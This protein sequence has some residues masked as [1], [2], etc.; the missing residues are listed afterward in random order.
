MRRII[1]MF[2]LMTLSVIST[3]AQTEF[4]ATW[5]STASNYRGTVSRI[6]YVCPPNGS[7]ATVWGSDLYTDD[8]SVCN[9]AVH[10]GLITFGSGGRVTIEIRAG[11][12]SYQGTT[13]NG[14]TT[15]SYGS[16]GGSYVFV[17]T[18]SLGQPTTASG[19]IER[20]LKS[21]DTRDYVNAIADFNEAIRLEPGN[22]YGYLNRGMAHT[23]NGNTEQAMADTNRAVELLPSNAT[24]FANRSILYSIAKN[25]IA[26]KADAEKAINLDPA[27]GRGYIARGF[28][29]MADNADAALS[30]IDRGIQL[31]PSFANAYYFRGLIHFDKHQFDSARSD[32]QKAIDLRSDIDDLPK[33]RDLA[34]EEWKKVSAPPAPLPMIDITTPPAQD[35]AKQPV[36]CKSLE[37]RVPNKT[38]A[39]GEPAFFA[40]TVDG[41]YF[42]RLERLG[43]AWSTTAGKLNSTSDESTAVLDTST[44]E[45]PT[46]V[47]VTVELGDQS[48]P[49]CR[50][51]SFASASVRI[52]AP[53]APE[54]QMIASY[55]IPLDETANALILNE[56]K[57]HAQL[58]KAA[59]IGDELQVR[60]YS[61]PGA[62][63]SQNL[64]LLNALRQYL[65]SNGADVA[66]VKFV[67]KGR[68]DD[69]GIELW[70]APKSAAKP[71]AKRR[72]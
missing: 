47:T 31:E 28:S 18:A 68:R 54:G 17:G 14:I 51:R 37:V 21:V 67:D 12:S 53:V 6:T 33:W 9:A 20:G 69:A 60:A 2:T 32:F 40:A 43:Y 16:W 29:V 23:R 58:V 62:P 55:Y 19:F 66:A 70:M 45:A 44:I 59:V 35:T 52:A 22:G 30:D 42:A 34:F 7:L 3:F 26:A 72:R 39:P 27:Y 61:G 13:R 8:S 5:S 25:K 1:P 65:I 56:V 10:A 41:K 49:E 48:I 50:S 24:A 4:Y 15:N 36:K 46:I 11:A 57:R 64:K 71:V 63:A 38:V